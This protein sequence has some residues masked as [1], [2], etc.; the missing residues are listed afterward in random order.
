MSKRESS[1]HHTGADVEPA[2][3]HSQTRQSH[4]RPLRDEAELPKGSLAYL[5]LQRH[6]RLAQLNHFELLDVPEHASSTTIRRAFQQAVLRFHPDR[7]RGEHERLRPLAKEIINQ[8]GVAYRVL[9]DDTTREQYRRSLAEYP[10]LGAVRSSIPGARPSNPALRVSSIPSVRPSMQ[11]P[12]VSSIP[13]RA[14]NTATLPPDGRTLP[15][16]ACT[17][18]LT[19]GCGARSS[20]PDPA[21]AHSAASSF[22]SASSC[23]SRLA[24]VICACASSSKS[25]RA[26]TASS[27]TGLGVAA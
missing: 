17:E 26:G 23:L 14:S 22:S 2:P 18:E 6:A 11:A 24:G 25:S 3:G 19:Q 10:H 27:G 12:R 4:P 20:S 9:E 1:P 13:V 16:S 21:R 15:V 8:I 5:V 7:L